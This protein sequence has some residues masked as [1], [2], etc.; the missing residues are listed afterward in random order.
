MVAVGTFTL[1]KLLQLLGLTTAVGGGAATGAAVG[2]SA[3]AIA[4][5][6]F[7]S[8]NN[9]L[10]S[11]FFGYGMI[12]GERLMYQKD[13]PSIQKRLD[14]GETLNAI[15]GD[16]I[17][18]SSAAVF[19]QAKAIFFGV[20]K[21]MMDTF[22]GVLGLEEFSGSQTSAEPP[23]PPKTPVDPFLGVNPPPASID[24]KSG[25][26][27]IVIDAPKTPIRPVPKSKTEIEKINAKIDS[28]EK[29]ITQKLLLIQ[30]ADNTI[31]QVDRHR[32]A[33][34][35]E[36]HRQVQLGRDQPGR[37]RVFASAFYDEIEK[38][39]NLRKNWHNQVQEMRNQ[40]GQ[41]K[42]ELK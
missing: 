26:K 3:S 15:L 22:S 9:F 13:W 19:D 20:Q 5:T 23:E 21:E 4:M 36:Y 6:P 18:T 17:G 41:L 2:G 32:A 35:Q 28:L 38:W 14:S 1:G 27:V 30:G 33:A 25:E 10:G 37:E 29:Q 24:P 16:Y 31:I 34:V 12:L 8:A 7:N 39:N 11:F 42:S 40:I